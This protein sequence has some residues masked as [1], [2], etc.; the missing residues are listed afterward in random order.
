MLV[1]STRAFTSPFTCV[2]IRPFTQDLSCELFLQSR[3]YCFLHLSAH[4]CPHVCH[5]FLLLSSTW[6]SLAAWLPLL[7][8]WFSSMS[9]SVRADSKALK[10]IVTARACGEC[11]GLNCRSSDPFFVRKPLSEAN[12][13]THNGTKSPVRTT[14]QQEFAAETCVNSYAVRK[15]KM[16]KATAVQRTSCAF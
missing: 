1:C 9:P 10:T 11:S 6:R 14:T 13:S 16:D 8:W 7:L 5:C 4:L 15:L 2:F 3:H 12:T